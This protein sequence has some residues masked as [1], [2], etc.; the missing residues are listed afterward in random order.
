MPLAQLILYTNMTPDMAPYANILLK[1]HKETKVPDTPGPQ[2]NDPQLR[3][4]NSMMHNHNRFCNCLHTLS[5][6]SLTTFNHQRVIEAVPQYTNWLLRNNAPV[7]Q[8]ILTS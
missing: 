2:Y 7:V 4:C 6:S 3:I 8:V 1:A 5:E